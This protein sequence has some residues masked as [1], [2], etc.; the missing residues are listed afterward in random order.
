[1]KSTKKPSVLVVEDEHPLRKVLSEKF[2]EEGF[3][4]SNARNGLEGLVKAAKEHPDMILL[5]IV[6][7]KMDG[8]TM[9]SKLRKTRWGKNAEVV[10]LTNL[11][12]T[13]KVAAGFTRGVYS[14]LVKS[15]WKLNDVVKLVRKKLR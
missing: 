2:T 14:Y 9:L 12:D 3:R 7:P 15:D 11:S 1:M 5:D 10:L 13:S 4:V 6:M 8:I